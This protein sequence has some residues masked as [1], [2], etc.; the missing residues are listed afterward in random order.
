MRIT[1]F[2]LAQ[3]FVGL[4]EVSGVADNPQVMSMLK[5]DTDWPEHDEVA[6]CSAFTNYICWL[7]RLPRSKSLLA[8]SWLNVGRPIRLNEGRVGFDVVILK[9]NLSDPGAEDTESSGH[10]GFY[11]GM[12]G[13]DVYI[14]GGNQNNGVDLT[15]YDRNRML[16][17]RRLY[18]AYSV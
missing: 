6:W 9:R 4:K 5:L 15:P 12:G 17:I 16:G 14:L 1:A 13:S 3:R 2:E 10:V 18:D 11:A 8:R 7:L